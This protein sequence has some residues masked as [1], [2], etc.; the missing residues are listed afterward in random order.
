MKTFGGWTGCWI[1]LFLF[2]IN[3]L[4]GA[5]GAGIYFV[6]PMAR[7][8]II[9]AACLVHI[10]CTFATSTKVT[11]LAPAAVS[12]IVLVYQF[13]GPPLRTLTMARPGG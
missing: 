6:F 3:E 11:Q 7:L 12:L 4:A 10:V 13:A 1:V 8:L 5:R 2:L 9:P